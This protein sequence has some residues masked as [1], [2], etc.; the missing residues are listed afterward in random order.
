ME[1]DLALCFLLIGERSE[2]KLSC[3]GLVMEVTYLNQNPRALCFVYSMEEKDLSQRLSNCHL[4]R[5][6]GPTCV[7]DVFSEEL[8]RHFLWLDKEPLK[9]MLFI[10]KWN[11]AC[12]FAKESSLSHIYICRCLGVRDERVLAP[13]ITWQSFIRGTSWGFT[14]F[15]FGQ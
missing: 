15:D 9:I 6:K 7:S 1:S 2:S 10:L 4:G 11:F 8:V 12:C 14:A 5:K 13:S 3:V